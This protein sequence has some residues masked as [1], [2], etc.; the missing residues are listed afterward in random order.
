MTTTFYRWIYLLGILLLTVGEL[1]AQ[2]VTITGKVTAKEDNEPLPG[3]NVSVDGTTTGTVTAADGT[4]QLNVPRTKATLVFSSIGYISDR[5]PLN[6]QTQLN[7]SLAADVKSLSEVV[8]V[9]YGTVKKSDLTGSLAQVKAKE[10]NA[11]PATNV[12]QALSG[13]APGVQVI[14]NSGAP[15]GGVS[16]RIRGTN[17]IQGSNEPLYVVDGF[18]YSSGTNPTVLNNSDIE[19]IEIL[20]DA[21]A[22]AIYG[23]RGANGVVLITTKRGKAGK[24][25]VDLET[26]YSL[27]TLRKKLDLMNGREYATFYNEQA[28]NDGLAPRF[29]PDEIAQI[30]DGFDWQEVIFQRA[31]MQN[32]NLTVSGGTEKTQFSVAG[33][34]FK[35]TGIVIGSDYDRYSLRANINHDI[36]KKFSLSYGATLTRPSSNRRNSGGGNRGG[37][38]ISS[39]LSAP[40]TLTPYNED[41]TYRNLATAYAWGSNVL[42]NP[43]NYINEQ[44]DR[45]LVNK[46]LANSALTFKPIPE[47]AIR[48]FGGVETSDERTDSYTTLNFIN[49][50]GS[51]SVNTSQFIS[52]LNENTITYTKTFRQ[53]H[54]LSALV[55]FTYQDFVNTS[56]SGSGN[57]FLSD[58]TDTYNLG[59]ANVPGIPGSGYSKSTLVSYLSRLNYGYKGKYLATLSFRGDGSSRYSEGSKW[60]YF[61]SGALAWRVSEEDFLKN[62]SFLSDLKFRAGWGLT[63]SQAIGAYATLN[64]LSSGKTVFGDGIFTTYAPGTRLP[65]NLKWETTAQTDVGIDAAFMSNRIRVTA[66]YY[67]KNTRDLLN[68]VSLPSSLGF[69]S[70]IQNVGSIQNKG[71][72][73]SVDANILNGTFK[74]DASA[75]FSVNRNKVVKLYGG[76]DVLGSAIN[77]TVVNDVINI[78]REGQP[79]GSFYGYREKGYDEKG[80]IQYVDVNN[81]GLINQNDKQI[82]GN[83]NPDFIYGFNS[84]MSYKNFELTLFFQGSKGNDIFNLSAVNQTLDYGFGLN[85]PREVYENHWT[86]TNTNAKYPVISRTTATFISDRFVED[87]S[88]LRLRNIQ[89]AYSV[90]FQKW[91]V[92]WIRNAQV[93]VS[94]QNLLTLTKYSWWDPE[95]NSYGGTNSINQGIDHYSYPTAKTV[96]FG[97]RAGF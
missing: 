20:K 12:L 47:L 44:T 93:Y 33:S 83:P 31:P 17:S 43:L 89:L 32:H 52:L 63:G 5:I 82:I 70:T 13:R 88:Y 49:S 27:Q 74:W 72:E 4:Y 23:S 65:G 6:G 73:F 41:G 35:Q 66:D 1:H 3:V 36:S 14:Q 10:I 48:V 62:V 55:G 71:F 46:V 87:G 57:G 69:T 75:N 67:V 2:T 96:T 94:G 37:S 38:M 28:A 61:P 24:T 16:V 11:F 92:S 60:G 58:A 50:Q 18:P 29:T 25:I 21:S 34:I 8:V 64:Q 81:D 9:G 95:I 51:A 45:I 42:T 56:L 53:H 76:R 97:L 39:V 68:T 77:I 91:G 85:M 22:T 80:K 54:N 30:G 78:L 15:G 19:S 7:V 26:S 59:S 84:T 86:P 79:L 90:P 40:P